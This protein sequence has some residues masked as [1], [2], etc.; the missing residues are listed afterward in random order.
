MRELLIQYYG[1]LETCPFRVLLF[2]NKKSAREQS[3]QGNYK[4]VARPKDLNKTLIKQHRSSSGYNF[5]SLTKIEAVQFEDTNEHINPMD[6]THD[7]THPIDT[8]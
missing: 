3:L 4:N 5:L 1:K 2:I 8:Q 7:D 6:N